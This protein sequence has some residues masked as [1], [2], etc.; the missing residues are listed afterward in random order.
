MCVCVCVCVSMLFP[1]YAKSL[2]LLC[3]LNKT[4]VL[5][6]SQPDSNLSCK[7]RI[8]TKSHGTYFIFNHRIILIGI[9]LT[10]FQSVKS[11]LSSI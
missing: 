1:S 5:F 4:A 8:F 9:K 11:L 3:H 6:I 7:I 10:F 2:I